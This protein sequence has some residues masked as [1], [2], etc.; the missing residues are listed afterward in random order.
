LFDRNDVH[1][2]LF[3]L[4]KDDSIDEYN[5]RT[6]KDPKY[7]K[8]SKNILVDH[9]EEYLQLFKEYM[10]V[11]AWRYGDLNW[12]MPHRDTCGKTYTSI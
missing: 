1:I 10:D 12:A 11:F 7:I 4:P 5:I 2:K 3:V 9:K 6:E 8:L